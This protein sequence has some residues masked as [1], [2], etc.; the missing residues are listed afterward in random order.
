MGRHLFQTR[1]P[2]ADEILPIP[3][4]QD[5]TVRIWGLPLDLTPQEAAKIGAVIAALAN[6]K[7]GEG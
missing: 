3:L 1:E 2:L 5:V 6:P 4:R 7:D